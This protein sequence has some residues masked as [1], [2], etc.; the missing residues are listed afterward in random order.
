MEKKNRKILF[1]SF[2]KEI[3]LIM[4]DKL[5]TETLDLLYYIYLTKQVLIVE[6]KILMVLSCMCWS[7][8]ENI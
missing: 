5:Q 8:E 1:Q 4:R 2:V 3:T 6:P 7:H